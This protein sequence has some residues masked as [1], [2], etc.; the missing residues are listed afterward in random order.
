[1]AQERLA[2]LL[3]VYEYIIELLNHTLSRYFH[4]TLQLYTL[5]LRKTQGS[6]HYNLAQI[7]ESWNHMV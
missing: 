3:P 2:C 5:G 6:F 1:M 4:T 7:S